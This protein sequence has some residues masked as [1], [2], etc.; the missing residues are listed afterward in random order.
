MTN[1]I[2]RRLG[3]ESNVD[4]VADETD[5]DLSDALN[6]PGDAG[7]VIALVNALL[8]DAV[9]TRATDIHLEPT[10]SEMRVRYRVDGLL[11]DVTSL[12][13]ELQS[14]V[15]SRIKIVAG[16]DIS[17]R[18]QPQDG[19]VRIVVDGR[20]IDSRVSSVPIRSGEKLVMRLLHR[21]EGT[22]LDGL[23]LE[24]DQLE[25]LANQLQSAQGLIVFTGP[26]GAGKTSTMYAAL[27]SSD[28]P[29]KNLISIEDPVEF[30]ISRVNQIQI[31]E[32]GGV[33]FPRGLRSILRQD[34]DVIMVGEV[35]DLET[36]ELVIRA[37]LTG[38]LVVS[39]L[40]ALDAGSAMERL[41]GLGLEPFRV[42]SAV[43]MVVAQR[44]VR[45]I[46]QHCRVPA[47]ADAHTLSLLGLKQSDVDH[48][49]LWEGAGCS[50]CANTG[51]SGR[52]GLFEV[53]PITP[54]LREQALVQVSHVGAL[55]ASA[56]RT[57]T[58]R[59]NGFR[60][61]AR[62]LTT[63]EEVLRV[64]YI[65]QDQAPTCPNCHHDVSSSF[66]VCPYCQA[67]LGAERCPGCEG[68]VV[69]DWAVCPHCETDLR[70]TDPS[71][72]KE[73]LLWVDELAQAE[74]LSQRLSV[75]WSTSIV[76]GSEEAL[77][78]AGSHKPNAVVVS[79]AP[80]D[81]ASAV[82]KLRNGPLRGGTIILVVAPGAPHEVEM[83]CLAA[84][85]G[86]FLRTSDE[87]VVEAHIA[88]LLRTADQGGDHEPP[89]NVRYLLPP[90]QSPSQQ[91]PQLQGV[92]GS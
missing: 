29:E 71:R 86:A 33:T 64:T 28:A 9:R 92:E 40:H 75:R 44:L 39:S 6:N 17:E 85:A 52:T 8:A 55:A 50:R 65:E 77:R 56:L 73:L 27:R 16:M 1:E 21:P 10:D 74:G 70:P 66:V 89:R 82:E 12:P 11:R 35:R 81:C 18:R 80:S 79:V 72:A 15:I 83:E 41:V 47:E 13:K 23:G 32:K 60:K 48:L 2:V 20:E 68:A 53:L 62:G 58:L 54:A 67:D 22:E 38:H 42:A 61:V 25:L 57:G 76:A 90:P 34:P 3:G 46:C 31:D 37:A 7:G 19:R 88:A 26:T 30:Q 69:A 51:Y 14:L 43:T 49:Q 84:G 24:S 36:A 87:R 91:S 78:S 4:I 63:L 59:E 45:L 5:Q